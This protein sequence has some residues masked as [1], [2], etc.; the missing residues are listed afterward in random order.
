MRFIRTALTD[1]KDHHSSGRRVS[2]TASPRDSMQEPGHESTSADPMATPTLAYV[3]HARASSNDISCGDDTDGQ[4][5]V[6]VF[7]RQTSLHFLRSYCI[8]I[9]YSLLAFLL[10]LLLTYL[11][12]FAA[13]M[14]G[15]EPEFVGCR[16]WAYGD[17]C[18]LWG[19]DC[20]PFESEWSAFRCPTKCNLG[21]CRTSIRLDLC[22]YCKRCNFVFR[23]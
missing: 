10:V 14:D 11:S 3:R 16:S 15:A 7:S 21:T 6:A 4:E 19:I 18:G 9:G 8:L 13:K 2:P 20:R 5:K 12:F 1:S 23:W 17:S 22:R